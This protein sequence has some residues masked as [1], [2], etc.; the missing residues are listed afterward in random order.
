[1]LNVITDYFLKSNPCTRARIFF[2]FSWWCVVLVGT[3]SF[4]GLDHQTCSH[5]YLVIF[6]ENILAPGIEAINQALYYT[7]IC[8]LT[9]IQSWS[10]LLM[11]K[12]EFSWLANF[13]FNKL[14]YETQIWY[15]PIVLVFQWV[16]LLHWMLSWIWESYQTV[17]KYLQYARW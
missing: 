4:N 17:A 15:Q 1:V 5:T 9:A 10:R 12:Y 7:Y 16:K 13:A 3:H 11:E 8:L 6:L 2:Q 14:K